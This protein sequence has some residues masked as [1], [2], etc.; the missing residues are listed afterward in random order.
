M[1]LNKISTL[2]KFLP[3]CTKGYNAQD[4]LG[5]YVFVILLVFG[6]VLIVYKNLFWF[7]NN[8]NIFT[9]K[10]IK[11]LTI[12]W[13]II[14]PPTFYFAINEVYNKYLEELEKEK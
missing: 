14:T 3:V 12:W 7:Y 4:T 1:K 2:W 13:L 11:Q 9:I 5:Y 8:Y 6:A 10:M